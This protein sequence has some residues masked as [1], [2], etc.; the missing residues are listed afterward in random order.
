MTTKDPSIKQLERFANRTNRNIHYSSKA[1]PSNAF[2]PVKHHHRQVYIPNNADH[3]SILVCHYDPKQFG[4]LEI[5]CGV[6]FP[7][8]S[9]EKIIIRQKDILDKLNIFSGNNRAKTGYSVFDSKTMISKCSDSSRLKIFQNQK[10]QEKILEAFS[11]DLRMKAGL[12]A[13]NL[14]FVNDLEGKNHLGLYITGQWL[15][16]EDKLEQLFSIAETI[17]MQILMNN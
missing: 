10:I 1:Y 15:L 14:D 9:K 3:T 7:I 6:F 8:S 13:M 12:N 2:A 17:R 4:E 11:L 16:E 5:Y